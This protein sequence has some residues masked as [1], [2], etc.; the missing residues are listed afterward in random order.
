MNNIA[1][2]IRDARINMGLTQKGLAEA[3][4][5]SEST[6]QKWEAGKNSPTIDMFTQILSLS[7]Q[8]LTV[9]SE[10]NCDMTTESTSVSEVPDNT[11]RKITRC[12]YMS[13]I[14]DWVEDRFGDNVPEWAEER[15]ESGD[16]WDDDYEDPEAS[17]I[18]SEAVIP[19]ESCMTSQAKEILF[20]ELCVNE[21]YEGKISHVVSGFGKTTAF[22][23]VEGLEIACTIPEETVPML[24]IGDTCYIHIEH[25]DAK[26]KKAYG[27]VVSIRPVFTAKINCITGNPPVALV[28]T[29]KA[30][31]APVT[32]ISLADLAEAEGLSVAECKKRLPGITVDFGLIATTDINDKR[33][34]QHGENQ[35]LYARRR[36]QFWY[37]GIAA[38]TIVEAAIKQV[39]SDEIEAWAHGAKIVI[40]KEHVDGFEGYPD[41]HDRFHS[42]ETCFLKIS[43]I[44]LSDSPEEE[45]YPVSVDAEMIKPKIKFDDPCGELLLATAPALKAMGY[46]ITFVN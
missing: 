37:K 46:N 11:A 18:S 23:N 43:D 17:T 31:A 13:N 25:K 6:V 21:V 4:F 20:K 41:L 34:T 42:D 38:G 44:T 5:V 9:I 33:K 12:N 39:S 32:I 24:R 1:E 22:V 35:K 16:D 2:T 45:S 40:P 7:G 10:S 36:K 15:W 8:K 26:E 3:L 19:H 27:Q 14:P 28:G 29:D 30:D